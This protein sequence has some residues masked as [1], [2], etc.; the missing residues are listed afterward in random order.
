MCHAYVASVT[1]RN[2]II[3]VTVSY[4]CFDAIKCTTTAAH[5]ASI[6]RDSPT[7]VAHKIE[8]NISYVSYA[9][10]PPFRCRC[11]VAVSPFPLAIA[12]AVAYLFAVYG[13]EFS[14]VILQNDG[15][16]QR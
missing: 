8:K 1:Y 4:F 16:L 12:A 9:R 3:I 5:V 6:I 14:Y 2:S 13:T 10:F 15:I 11:S 7:N